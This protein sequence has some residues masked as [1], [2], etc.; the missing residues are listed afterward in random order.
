MNSLVE[1]FQADAEGRSAFL[2][3]ECS[4]VNPHTCEELRIAWAEGFNS[5]HSKWQATLYA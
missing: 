5:E 4:T 1:K 2:R 3:G